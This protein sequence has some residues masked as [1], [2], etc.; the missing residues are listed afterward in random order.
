MMGRVL[1]LLSVAGLL[2][3]AGCG[4][5]KV[6]TDSREAVP[7]RERVI[8]HRVLPGEDLSRIADN[9]YGDPG[10]VP[11]LARDNGL[12]NPEGLT[13]GSTLAL[14]FAPDE[15][16]Q[17]QRRAAAL[18]AYNKGVDLLARERLAEAGRQFELAL[19]TAPQLL[20]ARYN[21]ALVRM[22]RGQN[23]QALVLL[24]ELTRQRPADADFRFARASA[25]FALTRFDEAVEQFG[26][27][28][29]KD[30]QH[31]RAQYGLARSLEA[32]GKKGAAIR[33]WGRYLELDD[34]SSWASTARRSLEALQQN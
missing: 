9:Y 27:V 8:E 21:L 24:E 34:S 11:Q 3:V 1:M 26:K 7:S 29:E 28:L 18:G 12:S 5:R 23:D 33:A 19:D 2:L 17:A 15:W 31:S 32:A 25:L 20:A 10:R 14:R 4:G 6:V 30:P 22:Q 16:E 13:E